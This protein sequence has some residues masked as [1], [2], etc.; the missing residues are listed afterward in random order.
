M[1]NIFTTSLGR[2]RAI[3]FLE[4]VSLIVLLC[5]TMPLKYAM[6]MPRPSFI[7]GL[8]HGILF[9]LFMLGLLSVSI[10]HKWK[11]A[12]IFKIVLLSCLV[13]FGFIYVEKN[14]LSKGR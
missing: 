4:G 14:M 1:K 7:A 3:A 6:D 5:I 11:A 8:V 13:P 9:L 2:F 12:K 10:E